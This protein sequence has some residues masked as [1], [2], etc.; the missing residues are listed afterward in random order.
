MYA[1]RSQNSDFPSC[2]CGGQEG[3]TERNQG[4]GFLM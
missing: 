2:E 4:A 3:V 1:S